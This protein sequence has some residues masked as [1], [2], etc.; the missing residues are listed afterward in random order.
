MTTTRFLLPILAGVALGLPASGQAP[1]P[2]EKVTLQYRTSRDAVAPAKF[3]AV[4]DG[5]ITLGLD[6]AW[7]LPKHADLDKQAA[8]DKAKKDFDGLLQNLEN[9]QINGV[10][11]D[12][13]GEW[14]KKGFKLRVVTVPQVTE[15]GAKRI[16]DSGN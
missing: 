12:C 3:V 8:Q 14:V 13:R 9:R 5:G 15:A 6:V 10:E 7:D 2:P 4:V 1:N 11:F 16:K